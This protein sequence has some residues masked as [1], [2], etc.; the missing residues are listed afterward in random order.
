MI[1]LLMPS[2]VLIMSP[3]MVARTPWY[4]NILLPG[5]RGEDDLPPDAKLGPDDVP[6]DGGQDCIAN[7]IFSHLEREVRMISL[8]M[9]SLV[10][11]MSPRMVVRTPWLS[12]ILLP[13][14][15]GEDDLP[16]DAKLGPNHVPQDGGQDN[17]LLFSYLEREMRMISLLMPR[18]VLQ[19]GGQDSMIFYYYLSW[20]ERWG[21]SPS[22][23]HARSWWCRPGWWPGLHDNPIFSNLEREVRMISLLMPSL[24]LI[25]A[26]RM[27]ARTPW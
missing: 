19:D 12:S 24:V 18:L 23:F 3:R 16:P 27:V 10:L 13:G 5:E 6:Q 20:R 15:R 17:N 22:W 14:E 2:L 25:I 26:P 7:P 1:S 4:S 9:P 21:W 11:M 8:L